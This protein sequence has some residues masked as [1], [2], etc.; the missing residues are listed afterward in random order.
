MNIKELIATLNLTLI[1]G[2]KGIENEITG[3]YTS[4]LLSDVMGN[5]HDGNVWITL[6]THKNV[7]AIASLRDASAVILVKGLQ[8]DADMLEK[9]NE[10]GIPVLGTELP[11]FEISG[12]LYQLINV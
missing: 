12:K 9:A 8:P 2:E 5:I 11:T 1:G 4:D 10:E 7:M 6:Q 3:A